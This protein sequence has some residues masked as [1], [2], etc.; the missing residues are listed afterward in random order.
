V[1]RAAENRSDIKMTAACVPAKGSSPDR[2]LAHIP[3]LEALEPAEQQA[4]LATMKVEQFEAHHTVVWAG[5]KGGTFYVISRGE[6]AISVPNDQ[7]EHV[8]LALLGPGGFFGEISLLDGGPRTASARTTAWTELYTLSR[9][10]FHAFL[11]RRPEV[12]IRLL[13]V[14][15]ARQRESLQAIR[16]VKNPNAVFAEEHC[17]W[18]ERFGDFVA[19]IAAGKTFSLFHVLWFTIWILINMMASWGALPH[20]WGFDPFPFGFLTMTV[21]L[22]AI[23]LSICVMISQNRQTE[24]DRVRTD[25]DHHINVKAQTEIMILHEKIDRLLAHHRDRGERS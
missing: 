15:G 4:L 8:Q 6:V 22:E 21:S 24:K 18:W 23:M 25:L 16:G 14:M 13:S 1:T 17:G 11:H 12:A 2:P 20:S 10:D 7:G 9:G 3:F 5:E 19:R